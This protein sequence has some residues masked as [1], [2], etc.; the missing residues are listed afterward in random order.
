MGL[1]REAAVPPVNTAGL[2]LSRLG[3]EEPNMPAISAYIEALLLP[4]S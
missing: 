3:A 4:H 1:P 2:A